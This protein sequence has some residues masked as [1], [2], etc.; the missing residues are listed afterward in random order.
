MTVGDRLLLSGRTCRSNRRIRDTAATADTALSC[1]RALFHAV[2]DVKS[3]DADASPLQIVHDGAARGQG[4]AADDGGLPRQEDAVVPVLALRPGESPRLRGQNKAHIARLAEVEA[5]LPP[6]LVERGS[7]KVVDGMHRLIAASLKG[8]ETID[9]KYFEGSPAEAFLRAVAENVA[10]GLPLS[11]ADRRAAAAR[12]IRSHPHMSD[13]AIGATVGVA[14]RTVAALRRCSTDAVPQLN[15]RVGQDGRVRPL[16]GAEG[17]QRAAELL[18]QNPRATLREVAQGA[19]VSPA[20][21]RDVRK[22]LERG[23][24]PA[25]T[26]P[27][28]ALA[29]VPAPGG[30]VDGLRVAPS[31]QASPPPRSAMEKLLRDPSLRQNDMG[32]RLLRWLHQNA[33]SPQDRSAF[34]AAVPIHSAAM[35]AQLARHYAQMWLAFAEELDARVRSFDLQLDQKKN[36]SL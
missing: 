34:L 16:N 18:R 6:I 3:L 13:R 27:A 7:M 19:G 12:I 9:V 31:R 17:R 22:R 11:Q 25:P 23:E 14:A 35:V 21:A 15:R 32:R 30:Q 1:D 2:E 26:R 5:P 8:R 10:H 28:A 20:T 29:R 24:D 36:V 33:M 4:A